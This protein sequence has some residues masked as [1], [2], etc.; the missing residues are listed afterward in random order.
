MTRR[1]TLVPGRAM[2][3]FQQ[4][5]EILQAM[6]SGDADRAEMLK[7]E[8]IRSAQEWFQKYQKYLL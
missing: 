4:H 7:R 8:N 2:K 6:R 5:Q 3:G 1:L